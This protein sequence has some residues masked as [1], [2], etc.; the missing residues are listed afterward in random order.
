MNTCGYNNRLPPKISVIKSDWTPLY[1]Q[2]N[3]C[4]NLQR[5][6]WPPTG[7]TTCLYCIHQTPPTTRLHQNR[8]H[9]SP[10]QTCNT[11]YHVYFSCWWLWSEI[12]SQ[13][14]CIAFDRHTEEKYPGI[15]I[16]WSGRILLGIHLYW[17]YTERTVTLSM[18]NYVKKNPVNIP[19]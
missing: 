2:Q 1:L 15:T 14:W 9:T 13:K 11:R 12:Y 4:R 10:L 3:T 16:Y 18:P 8:F 5:H 6:V 17:E 7:S 19:K